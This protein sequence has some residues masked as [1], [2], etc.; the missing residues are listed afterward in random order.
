MHALWR[1]RSK[2]IGCG[3][4]E[5]VRRTITTVFV[6]LSAQIIDMVGDSDSLDVP[7]TMGVVL[8]LVCYRIQPTV[9]TCRRASTLYY[10]LI[11]AQK[12]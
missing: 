1:S 11:S 3:S 5:T 2:L 7:Q 8:K 10:L 6:G 12:I 4:V 9:T